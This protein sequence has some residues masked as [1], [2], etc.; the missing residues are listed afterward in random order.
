[1]ITN[2]RTEKKMQTK[3][4][5][6]ERQRKQTKQSTKKYTQTYNEYKNK[7]E[8]KQAWQTINGSSGIK[9]HPDIREQE[10]IMTTKDLKQK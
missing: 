6:N 3:K 10:T 2:N 9:T 8:T 7:G 4:D 1:M 5:N